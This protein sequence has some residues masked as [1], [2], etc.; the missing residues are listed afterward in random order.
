MNTPAALADPVPLADMLA[1]WVDSLNPEAEIRYRLALCREA[2]ERGYE[3]GHGAGYAE[4]VAD[5]KAAEHG[6]Y[7]IIKD[8]HDVA[9]RRWHLCCHHCRLNGCHPNCPRCESRTPETFAD[10]RDDDYT[11]G[12]VSTR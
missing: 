11:G 4:A 8:N 12:P 10:P 9:E 6:I 5:V 3:R 7:R 2:E 1:A